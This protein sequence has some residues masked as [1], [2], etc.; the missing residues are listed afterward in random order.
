MFMDRKAQYC[1]DVSSFQCDLQIQCN[2]NQ[3]SRKLFCGYQQTYSKVYMEK[4]KTQNNQHNK[5]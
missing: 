4:Q 2:S 3:N 1:Q 5:Y